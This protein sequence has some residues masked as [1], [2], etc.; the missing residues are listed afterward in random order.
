MG[1]S[2]LLGRLLFQEFE[3]VAPGVIGE[4][5]AGTGEGS[6]IGY[7]NAAREEGLAQLVQIAGDEGGVGFSGRAEIGLDADMELLRAAFEP[8]TTSG[9]ERV[10]LWNLGQ[11]EKR[12]VEFAG[13]GFAALGSGD[14]NVIEAY[15]SKGHGSYRIA[16][17]DWFCFGEGRKQ[18]FGSGCA[19]YVRVKLPSAIATS[20]NAVSV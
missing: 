20:Q 14:L 15:D 18:L 1:L 9:T 6:V 10:R 3:A 12:A 11:A 13:G 16:A 4:K 5:T 7:L 2:G 19:L 8:A 17:L